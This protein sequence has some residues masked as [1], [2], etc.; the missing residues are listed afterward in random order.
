MLYIQE[1]NQLRTELAALRSTDIVIG[2]KKGAGRTPRRP[3]SAGP[4][5]SN[6]AAPRGAEPRFDPNPNPT[7]ATSLKDSPSKKRASLWDEKK[8]TCTASGGSKMKDGPPRGISATAFHSKRCTPAASGVAANAESAACVPTTERAHKA[9]ASGTGGSL[10][11]PSPRERWQ[12]IADCRRTMAC[13]A[14]GHGPKG[15]GGRN[16]SL[17]HGF[18][19]ALGG[20]V[21][22]AGMRERFKPRW[23]FWNK[24][25]AAVFS[26]KADVGERHMRSWRPWLQ[27]NAA[28]A[29]PMPY[30]RINALKSAKAIA[31][32]I[33]AAFVAIATTFGVSAV[34]VITVLQRQTWRSCR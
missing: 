23:G 27:R 6:G 24:K 31:A 16:R 33:I 13:Q 8:M 12:I 17:G 5:L 30:S 15:A 9:V 25:V 29:A 14:L 3:S 20:G 7:A 34:V 21:F 32:Y 4:R 11:G 10:G 2:T 19:T 28:D 26:G 22:A 18:L 1:A